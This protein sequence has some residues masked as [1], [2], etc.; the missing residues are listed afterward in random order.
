MSAAE[1][2]TRL[3]ITQ[4]EAA[5]LQEQLTQL[6]GA[7]RARLLTLLQQPGKLSCNAL[8]LGEHLTTES[9]C[10]SSSQGAHR[11]QLLTLLQHSRKHT[12]YKDILMCPTLSET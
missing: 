2:S 10:T 9:S 7:H 6:T 5:K 4:Q 11:A 1:G 8:M 12:L 3:R